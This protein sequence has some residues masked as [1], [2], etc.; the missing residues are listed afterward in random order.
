VPQFGGHQV[1]RHLP[2]HHICGDAGQQ[3]NQHH[4][5]HRDEDIGRDQAVAQAP[6]GLAQSAARQA[7]DHYH[8]QQKGQA[9]EQP[10]RHRRDSGEPQDDVDRQ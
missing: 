9:G 4:R 7:E 6:D 2:D 3:Q 10:L 1:H 5:H 8:G